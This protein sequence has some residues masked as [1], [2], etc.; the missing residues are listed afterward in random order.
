LQ[1]KV[2]AGAILVEN[3]DTADFIEAS[4]AWL[5]GLDAFLRRHTGEG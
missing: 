3:P 5:E 2:R 1:E 4:G